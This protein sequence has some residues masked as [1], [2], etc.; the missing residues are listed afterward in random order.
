MR[1]GLVNVLRASFCGR[2]CNSFWSSL[3]SALARV[4]PGFVGTCRTFPIGLWPSG[5]IILGFAG[6]GS[7]FFG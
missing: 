3:P 6:Y 2:A 1:E 7:F 5:G 4:R